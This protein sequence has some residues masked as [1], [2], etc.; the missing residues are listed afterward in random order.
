MLQ[1]F[2]TILLATTISALWGQAHAQVV[3]QVPSPTA[4]IKQ[5]SVSNMAA[6]GDTLWIGPGLNRTINNNP[7]WSYPDGATKITQG[8]GRVF[9]LALA[10]DT[11]WAGLGYNAQSPNG[12]VQAG[13][14]FHFSTDGGDTWDYIENPKEAKNDTTFIYGGK[15]YSKL[16]ITTQEQAP[17]FDIAIHGTTVLSAGWAL[18]IVRSKNFGK[19]WQRL[20]LPPQYADSLVP[21]QSYK[22]NGNGQNRYDP[23]YDQNLLGFAVMIDNQH[24]VW[25]GTAGGLD[26]SEDALTAPIDSLRWQH[27]QYDSSSDGLLSNWIITIRQ[28]PSNGDVWMT[29]WI[30]GL[31]D[32]ERYGIVR[33]SDGGQTFDQYLVGERIND[34]GFKNGVIFAAGDKGLFVSKDNGDNWTKIQQIQ[35][36]GTFIKSS[37]QYYSLASSN[38]RLWVGTSDGL[39]STADSGNT[40]Q[41]TRVNFPLDGSNQYQKDAPKVEAYAYPN[42]FSPRRHGIVRIKYNVDEPGNVYIRLYDFGMHLIRILDSGNFA[43]GTYEAVWDG[44]DA[45]GRQVANG[46]VFY[47]I[48]T[49]GNT[50]RGKIL[51]ID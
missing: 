48:D 11:V 24:N 41:I 33:T 15:T 3:G 13:L 22:F 30:S 8:K 9:S 45:H 29:N 18:G 23:R 31:D 5:N 20:L 28:Q 40:W 21:E 43:A 46:P 2:K 6:L 35:D 26:I 49:P 12:S 19:H 39:A 4:S 37:A 14:G 36:S 38:K 10:P 32:N 17:P 50:I 7:T 34:I 25:A 42:P 47:Q 1:A 51:V 44:T 27:V 16:P